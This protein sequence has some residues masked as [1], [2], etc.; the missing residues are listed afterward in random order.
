MKWYKIYF[1]LFFFSATL[2]SQ[3]QLNEEVILVLQQQE[4]QERTLIKGAE[5]LFYTENKKEASYLLSLELL[6]KLKTDASK[7]RLS[8]LISCYFLEE[9]RASDSAL[10]YSQKTIAFSHFSHD[11]IMQKRHLLGTMS[12]VNSH[13][14]KG[15]FKKARKVAIEGEEKANKWGF[16]EEHNRFLLYLGDI[17]S[18]EEKYDEAIVLLEKIV[19]SSDIDVAVGARM[20]L[21]RIY[22]RRKKYKESNAYYNSALEINQNPYYD[23]AIRLNIISN[24]KYTGKREVVIPLLEAIVD[25]AEEV[26]I[27]HLGNLAKKELILEYLYKKQFEQAEEIL[28]TLLEKRK[29]EGNLIEMLFCY[30]H[31]KKVALHYG[32]I[33]EVLAYTEDFML[34]SDAISEQEKAREINELEIKFQTLQKEKENT[35]L[36]KDK[37]KQIYIK[38]LILITSSVFIV[39]VLLFAFGYYQKL[40][41][42]KKINEIQKQIG[43]EKIHSLMKEQELKLIKASIEGQDRERTR[44]AQGLHDTIGNNMATIKLLMGESETLDMGKIQD[45]I[46]ET[47]QKVREI[48]HDTYPQ[49]N[50]QNEFLEIL[51]EYVKNIDQATD[52]H[53]HFEA[54]HEEIFNR[55]E[56]YIQNEIF[57]MLQEFILN[58]LKHA[59][60][61][62]IDIRLEAILNDLHLTYEDD[63]KGF[64]MDSLSESNGIGIKNIKNRV[65]ELSGTLLIDS[66]P[67]R[68]S[69]FK[70]EIKN[71]VDFL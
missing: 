53:I 26:K 66:H 35:Q 6:K 31:L 30:E 44:L 57:T 8:H 43:D 70:I 36:K 63:G 37:E 55:T 50:R 29:K 52:I 2:L 24:L 3:E 65:A 42:Q 62:N 13:L 11:S 10:F 18:Y 58:T 67:K 47:Y 33:E 1:Y 9:K 4:D 28:Q 17:Y 54:T 25:E 15:L 39:M 5:H 21:G 19:N 59:E 69:L 61:R 48:S 60:A 49:K 27:S 56:A 51:K 45:L 23:L 22:S 46:D 20:S 12:L 16:V 38:N 41:T 34:T 68:G 64:S 71:Q 14:S 40:Q 32:N 7:A